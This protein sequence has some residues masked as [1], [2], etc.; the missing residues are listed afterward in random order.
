MF[1]D[2]LILLYFLLESFHLLLVNNNGK[3]VMRSVGVTISAGV[4]L[5]SS[6]Q[7]KMGHFF[8]LKI[9]VFDIHT[10]V[11]KFLHLR[12]LVSGGEELDEPAVDDFS[13]F[14]FMSTWV[15]SLEVEIVPEL[16]VGV[17]FKG[18][19]E[20]VE[21]WLQA[22]DVSFELSIDIEMFKICQLFL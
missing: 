21:H 7:V 6:I 4:T 9:H 18:L 17:A 10:E 11:F 15:F 13:R 19:C 12:N 14:V 8:C 20:L 3:R 22:S 5:A 2:S 1:V 16:K